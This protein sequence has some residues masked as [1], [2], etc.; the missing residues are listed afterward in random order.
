MNSLTIIVSLLDVLIVIISP[1]KKEEELAVKVI[2]I[3][4]IL[5]KIFVS[6]KNEDSD[7]D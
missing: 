5:F 2:T 3:L 7:E 4:L 6:T 1:P